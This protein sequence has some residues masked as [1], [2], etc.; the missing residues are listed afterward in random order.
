M[1]CESEGRGFQEGWGASFLYRL[2]VM[3][4]LF[5]YSFSLVPDVQRQAYSVPA[6]QN[7]CISH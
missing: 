6:S 2:W 1:Q 4:L 7:S 3:L 5:F